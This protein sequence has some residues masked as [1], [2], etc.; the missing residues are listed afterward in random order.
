[1]REEKIYS[2]SVAEEGGKEKIITV[3]ES[4]LSKDQLDLILGELC[5]QYQEA[6][7]SVRNSFIVWALKQPTEI[8]C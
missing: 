8:L 1:M 3:R 5:S 7:L 4:D 2:F 6:P